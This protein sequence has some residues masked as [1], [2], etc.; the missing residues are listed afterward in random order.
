MSGN[1]HRPRV[2]IVDDEPIIADTL[3]KILE[4]EGYSALAAHDGKSALEYAKISTPQLVIADVMLSGMNGVDIGVAI[5]NL[6]PDCK[7]ILISGQATSDA[8]IGAAMSEGDHFVFLEK[9]VHPSVLLKHVAE[10][11]N[12]T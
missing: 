12:Q 10:L 11:L 6:F 5:R 4:H 7:I 1:D 9:P 2:L 3:A 8:L